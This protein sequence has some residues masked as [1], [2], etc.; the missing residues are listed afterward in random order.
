[1]GSNGLTVLLSK[2]NK[3]VFTKVTVVIPSFNQQEFLEEAIVSVLKQNVPTE[4]FVMDGGSTDG[5]VS[6]IQRYESKLSKWESGPDGGQASAINRGVS[7]GTSEYVCWVN[8]DDWLLPDA[9][10]SLTAALDENP[11]APFA[12]GRAWNFDQKTKTQKP[13]WV[14]RFSVKRLSLRCIVCQ[15][16]TLIRRSAWESCGG[17][18]EKLKMA[19]DYDLWWRL[20][21]H[22]G[23]PI[24]VDKFLATNRDHEHT[25]TRTNRRLHYKEAMSVV[26]RHFGS[27]PIK[28]WLAQPYSIWLRSIWW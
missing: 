8:S 19:M 5:S 14:E 9:L 7:L 25:K 24:F 23:Q 16:A 21:K 13:I 3:P 11:S 12:Y 22:S 1:M 4:V 20:L 27:I 18:D 17:A 10:S 6:V 15:P 28:W 2:P 26:K